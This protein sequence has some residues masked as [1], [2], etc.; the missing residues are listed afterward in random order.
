MSC[1]ECL[2]LF[3]ISLQQNQSM[4]QWRHAPYPST[5]EGGQ[6]GPPG[7]DG[8]TGR[9]TTDNGILLNRQ[10]DQEH[11]T[12]NLQLSQ[13]PSLRAEHTS[14]KATNM[15]YNNTRHHADAD[16]IL[17]DTQENNRRQQDTDPR[18]PSDFYLPITTALVQQGKLV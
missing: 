6:I 1:H 8:T 10:R 13:Q 11:H 14:I 12:D 2:W 7:Q 15:L 16:K 18:R 4:V 3:K 17:W 5:P 9:F